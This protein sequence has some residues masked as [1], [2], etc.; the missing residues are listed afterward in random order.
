MTELF[1]EWKLEVWNQKFE[2][3]CSDL[4][5]RDPVYIFQFTFFFK[6]KLLTLCNSRKWKEINAGSLAGAVSGQLP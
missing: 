4:W 2:V 6:W 5:S 3:K 1:M